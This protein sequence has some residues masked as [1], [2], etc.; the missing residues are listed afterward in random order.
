M[1]QT[2]LEELYKTNICI[3]TPYFQLQNKKYVSYVCKEKY[4]KYVTAKF[5][6]NPYGIGL[7]NQKEEAFKTDEKLM[8]L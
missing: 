2:K 6:P 1:R 8:P 3:L 4:V 7:S 5:K